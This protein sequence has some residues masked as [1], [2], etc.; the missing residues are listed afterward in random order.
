[1][2]DYLSDVE[3]P[4]ISEGGSLE[5]YRA[6]LARLAPLVEAADVVVPG[7]GSPHDRAT[8]LRLLDEDADYVDALERGDDRPKL[9]AGR[10]TKAQRQIH[11][12]N[13][14]RGAYHD[15]VGRVA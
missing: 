8:A 15:S 6:T 9:P 1:V 3:I 10:D 7:Y 11:A 5:G 13:L 4:M 12:E 14:A 2:G